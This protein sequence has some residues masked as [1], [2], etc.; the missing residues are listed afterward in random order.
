MIEVMGKLK[1]ELTRL[2]CVE[3]LLWKRLCSCRKAD[4]GKNECNEKLE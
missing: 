3:N 1:E 4:Y 2:H